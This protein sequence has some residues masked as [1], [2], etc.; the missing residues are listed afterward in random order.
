MNINIGQTLL[1]RYRIDDFIA[2]GNMGVVYRVWDLKR[3]VPLAMKILRTEF[4]E[5]PS[6]LKTFQREARALKKLSHPHIVPYYGMENVGEINFLLEHFIDGLSLSQVLKS[7][8]DKRLP[9]VEALVYLKAVC[10][11]LGYA[12]NS[13][14]IHCDVKPGNVMVD[15]GGTI[16]LTDFGIARH[17]DSTTTTIAGAGTP[18]YMA[19]EQIQAGAVSSA[20]DV[21]ALGVMFFE[22][23]TGRRPFIGSGD[24]SETAGSTQSERV[25]YAHLRLPPPDPRSINPQIPVELGQAILKALEKDPN[26]RFASTQEF[27]EVVCRAMGWSPGN[28]PDRVQGP[29]SDQTGNSSVVPGLSRSQLSQPS[30]SMQSISTTKQG[31]KKG[32]MAVVFGGLAVIAVMAMFVFSSPG[33]D[34]GSPTDQGGSETSIAVPGQNLPISAGGEMEQE[35]NPETS[36]F[37]QETQVAQAIE[38][39]QAAQAAQDTQIALGIQSTQSSVKTAV[40]GTAQAQQ[41]SQATQAFLETQASI[42]AQVALPP[43]QVSL[44]SLRI[45]YARGPVGNSDIFIANSDGSRETAIATRSCDEAEPDW[46]PD[47]RNIIFQSDCHGSY[48]IW[49]SDDLNF[50]QNAINPDNDKDQREPAVSP[51]GSKIA[52]RVNPK[53]TNRNANGEIWVMNWNGSGAQYLGFDGRS[54]AWSPDGSQIAYMSDASG[55]WQIY[56]HDLSRRTSK[57]ITDCS[58]NCRWPSWSPDGNYVVYNT[59]TSKTT[60]DPDGVWYSPKEGGSPRQVIKGGGAGRPCWSA[61]G[62]ILYNTATGIDIVKEDGSQSRTI[63]RVSTAWA[64]AC[65]D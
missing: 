54:P 36:T 6:I 49:V 43:T 30:M 9:P 52:F 61:T 1:N 16:Y 64:P 5:D 48:D 45:A 28:V 51:D 42:T 11:A 18:A 50:N 7:R 59:T 4:A 10:S 46:S 39:T 19:P 13:E 34:V 63:I 38:H 26:R 53:G 60:T 31:Q 44:S 47:G 62:W 2:P 12:H 22:M 65:S 15:R 21:Y 27:F 41:V 40:A 23:L 25:R 56:V 35:E 57:M 33:T 8:P 3:N 58:V 14:V 24:G 29:G 37:V 20:T 32:L 55:I 17:A